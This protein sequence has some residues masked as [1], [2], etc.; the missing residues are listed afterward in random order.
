[1]TATGIEIQ[2]ANG[3]SPM[4]TPINT[5]RITPTNVQASAGSADGGGDRTFF[6]VVLGT[7]RRGGMSWFLTRVRVSKSSSTAIRLRI[8]VSCRAGVRTRE[9]FATSFALLPFCGRE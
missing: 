9:S 3:K 6:E 7:N 4:A 1:M 5:E 8:F 2:P